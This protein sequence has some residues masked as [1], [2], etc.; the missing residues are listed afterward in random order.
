MTTNWKSSVCWWLRLLNAVL[1]LIFFTN[2]MIFFSL[3]KFLTCWCSSQI[4]LP[5]QTRFIHKWATSKANNHLFVYVGTH[6]KILAH[7]FE[8]WNMQ[9]LCYLTW[10]LFVNEFECLGVIICFVYDRLVWLYVCCIFNWSCVIK[11]N[12]FL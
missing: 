2:F 6:I 7:F 10:L 3:I 11:V 5:F 1:L 12:D 9:F 8:K 4:F